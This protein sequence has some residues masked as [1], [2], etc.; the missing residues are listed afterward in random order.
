M[1]LRPV[2]VGILFVV[3]RASVH[4]A[5]RQ[6]QL[7]IAVSFKGNT[8]F[9]LV[10][11]AAGRPSVFYGARG[12]LLGEIVGVEA[13]FGDAPS[14]FQPG[15]PAL[16]GGQV[17]LHSRVTTLTGNVVVALPR[18]MTEY[19]LRPFFVGGGGLMRARAEDIFG[20][21]TFSDTRPAIDVGGGVSG[22]ITSQV[23]LSWDL[24]YFRSL[25]GTDQ[26]G[27]TNFGQQLSFWRVGMALAVRF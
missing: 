17:V 20:V 22:F 19:T 18:R 3:S 10:Q 1:R 12:L 6:I 9:T 11:Y 24:R 16:P 27:G 4:A 5:E 21:L 25:S 13:D 26:N 2:L 7:F 8:T 14:F 23:G 15:D